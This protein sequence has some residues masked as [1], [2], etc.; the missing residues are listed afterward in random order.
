MKGDPENPEFIYKKLCVYSYIL[1]LQTPS[2]YSPF[3]AIHLLRLFFPLLKTGFE[4]VDSD[5]F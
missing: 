2:K 3:R 5:A 4:L 1:K